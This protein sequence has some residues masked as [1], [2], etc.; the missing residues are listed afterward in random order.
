M[1]RVARRA[2]RFTEAIGPELLACLAQ[3]WTAI[4]DD[5]PV[6]R[7]CFGEVA[8][9]CRNA[10][11]PPEAMLVGVRTLSR[12]FFEWQSPQAARIEH[13]WASAVQVLMNAYNQDGDAADA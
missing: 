12:S 3:E 6:E 11:I 10:A 5:V 13:A 1:N 2:D 4:G 9:S 7:S 8:L